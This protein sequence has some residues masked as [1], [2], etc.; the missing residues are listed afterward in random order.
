MAF[1]R[2]EKLFRSVA[3]DARVQPSATQLDMLDEREA[4]GPGR[5]S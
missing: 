4:P 5:S 2:V 1:L 3:L